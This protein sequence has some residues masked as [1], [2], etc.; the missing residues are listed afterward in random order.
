LARLAFV[1]LGSNLGHPVRRVRNAVRALEHVPETL[2]SGCSR[3]YRGPPMGPTDQPDY[4]NAVVALHTSLGPSR[5]LGVLQGI[6]AAHGRR[7]DGPRWGP[8]TL[9]L[10]LLLLGGLSCRGP[11]LVLP[12]PGLADRAF[13]LL[14]LAELA[15]ELEVPGLGRIRNLLA[16]V[17]CR[18]LVPVG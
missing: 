14:P 4:V 16:R 17:D 12:H 18:A 9:D 5:L 10:D 6:E 15:P 1:G 11:G 3:L 7:R 8:R 2:L 13:V